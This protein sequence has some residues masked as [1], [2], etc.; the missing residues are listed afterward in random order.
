MSFFFSLRFQWFSIY[1]IHDTWS[2]ICCD[3][4]M[5]TSPERKKN[6]HT[7]TQCTSIKLWFHLL[8]IESFFF[9]LLNISARILSRSH[10]RQM[11][12]SCTIVSS[13]ILFECCRLK[14]IE[15]QRRCAHKKRE[16]NY[17]WF[18][19]ESGRVFCFLGR[20]K[21]VTH[22]VCV[23]IDVN[24]QCRNWHQICDKTLEITIPK[25]NI[26]LA[27]SVSLSFADSNHLRFSFVCQS[28]SVIFH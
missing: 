21:T 23:Q 19:L 20:L 8:F 16:E 13:W 28:I 5:R 9:V 6:T 4:N 10:C 15:W 24:K 17:Y 18:T 11:F 3:L 25:W 22:A 27:Q 2:Y 14:S 1:M 26:H 12:C 7:Y